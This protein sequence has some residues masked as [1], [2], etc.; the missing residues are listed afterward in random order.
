[1]VKFKKLEFSAPLMLFP[2]WGQAV[3]TLWWLSLTKDMQTK[4]LL[5]WSGMPDTEH[6]TASGSNEEEDT[7]HW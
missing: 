4:Q 2:I 7:L 1:M 5:C 3:Y 6:R